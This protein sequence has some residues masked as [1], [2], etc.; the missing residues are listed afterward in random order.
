M[1]VLIL[2][3]GMGTRLGEITKNKPKCLVELKNIS[4]LDRLIKQLYKFGVSQKDIH[5]GAGYKSDKLP[6]QF[7]KFI[8]NQYRSTNMMKTTIIGIE[9]SF[10]YLDNDENLLVVY[11]DCVYSN[12][13]IKEMVL[14]TDQFK[15][16]TIPVDLQWESKWSNRYQNIYDDAE[17]LE[18][19]KLNNKLLS[20]GNK[21]LIPEEYMAQFMGIYV[22][23]NRFIKKFINSYYSFEIT[24]QE[25]ISTTEFFEKTIDI[26]NYHV[27]PGNYK[28]TEI[29]N[30]SDLLYA[31]KLFF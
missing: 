22:V 18:F 10:E 26:N 6:N 2:C 9:L 5:L 29:D 21:S 13:F 28:W 12:D 15:E 25:K 7:K 23:P 27:L 19:N 20:I 4:I 16:I 31:R 30:L 14:K 3:A 8:N 17:T 11:G 1:K 24:I